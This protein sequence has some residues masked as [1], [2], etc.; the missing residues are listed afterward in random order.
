MCRCVAASVVPNV[1]KQQHSVTPQKTALLGLVSHLMQKKCCTM[2]HYVCCMLVCTV[3]CCMF[4]AN[5]SIGGSLHFCFI[6]HYYSSNISWLNRPQQGR[7]AKQS[8]ALSFPLNIDPMA[9]K[10]QTT[11]H[12]NKTQTHPSLVSDKLPCWCVLG[13]LAEW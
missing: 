7:L 13:N 6:H 1:S 10:V 11:E 4:L 3:T 8:L 9:N 5:Y 12:C 2:K